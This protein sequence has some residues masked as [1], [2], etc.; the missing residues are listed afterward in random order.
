MSSGS[1]RDARTPAHCW[2]GGC[3]DADTSALLAPV[4]SFDRNREI[5]ASFSKT[6]CRNHELRLLMKIVVTSAK[7]QTKDVSCHGS[8]SPAA[9]N[10]AAEFSPVAFV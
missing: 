10:H 6:A 7:S 5:S 8:S 9:L 2:L 3:V 1:A 4:N